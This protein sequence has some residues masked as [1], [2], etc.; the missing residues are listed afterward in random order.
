VPGE[1][2]TLEYGRYLVTIAACGDCHSPVKQGKVIPGFEFAG[3]RD[4][5][6]PGAGVV[7]SANITSDK[8]TGIGT[9]TKEQFVARF[10]AYGDSTKKAADVGP[11]EFQT[12][13]PWYRYGDMKVTDLEAIYVYIKTIKPVKNKV[14][15][16][17][18][19]ETH[20]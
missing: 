1:K 18:P 2:D 15:K 4:F 14:T 11:V 12:I 17:M 16:F 7:N 19:A 8:T 13:M 9:W 6:I 3:G 5:T 20:D 10:K